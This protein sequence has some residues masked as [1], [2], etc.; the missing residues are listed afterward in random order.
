[1]APLCG[2]TGTVSPAR[3]ERSTSSRPWFVL[4][5]DNPRM[6]WALLHG[7]QQTMKRFIHRQ[8]KSRRPGLVQLSMDGGEKMMFDHCK[9]EEQAKCHSQQCLKV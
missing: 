7:R 4:G 5:A 2:E 6:G 3:Q 1:V 9:E 8:G